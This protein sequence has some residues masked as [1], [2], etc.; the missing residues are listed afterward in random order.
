MN[1][2]Q[3]LDYSRIFTFPVFFFL[4][5]LSTFGVLLLY[6]GIEGDFKLLLLLTI[7]TFVVM[8]GVGYV[9][10]IRGVQPTDT[11]MQQWRSPWFTFI[12]TALLYMFTKF[13]ENQ[14]YPIP[15]YF[16]EWDL[17]SW[18]K[19]ERLVEHVLMKGRK[20]KAHKLIM[21]FF[22]NVERGEG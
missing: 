6:G 2:K 4:N 18:K 7:P 10:F 3:W 20:A 9:F 12:N 21:E 15:A 5:L 8:I 1:L 16:E 14:N 22:K 19:L 17:T 13:A 11:T